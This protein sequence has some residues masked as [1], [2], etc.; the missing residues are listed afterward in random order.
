MKDPP[1]LKVIFYRRGDPN[2]IYP[3]L[4][5]V[6][7]QLVTV[8]LEGQA[9]FFFSLF[10]FQN[11][12]FCNM[13]PTMAGMITAMDDGI[14]DVVSALKA[15][16]MWQNTLFVFSSGRLLDTVRKN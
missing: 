4:K 8:S 9:P 16:N 14:G 15:N 13:F 12:I 5:L 3:D 11:H 6:G 10:C 7:T 2:C 1:T